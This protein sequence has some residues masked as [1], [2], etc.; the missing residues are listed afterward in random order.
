MSPRTRS[1]SLAVLVS[2]LV[3]VG[4]AGP[5]GA[6][7]P[8]AGPSLRDGSTAPT[9]TATPT[10]HEHEHDDGSPSATPS[11]TPSS[12]HEHEH[13]Q[14]APSDEHGDHG[15]TPPDTVSDSTRTLVIGG[16]GLLNAGVLAAAA[17][18]RRRQRA[19]QATVR[20]RTRP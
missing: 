5:A 15:T 10:S 20:P 18:V 6:L 7:S 2:V 13:G 17:L 9:S 19:A 14:D 1:G 11:P 4:G 12:G 8:A 16:F 3:V